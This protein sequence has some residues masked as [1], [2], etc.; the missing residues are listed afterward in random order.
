MTLDIQAVR[1]A[2]PA[3]ASGF[4][5]GD[6]A[7]GSQCLTDVVSRISDYLLNTNVQLGADYPVSVTSTNRVASGAEA[8]R[9]LFNAE[10][11]D[12]IAYGSSSTMIVEN[13]SRAIE[14]DVQPGEEIII[15]GE[16]ESNAGPWKKLAARKGAVLKLW[17]ATQ[18]AQ[19][20]DNPYAV[21]LQ[22]DALAPLISSKTR[23]V[24][25]TACSN[26][27]GSIVSVKDIISAARALAV[28]RGARK[29]EF[30]VDCVA[31]APH[32]QIDVQDW[33]VEYCYFSFYKVYGP[34]ASVLYARSTSL[35]HSLSS[36]AHH[37]LK[38]DAKPYKLQPGGP[39]YELV[40]GCTGVPPYLR[41]LTPEGTLKAAWTAIAQHEQ[42]LLEP[43]LAYLRAKR[44]RG[45]RIVGDE[46]AGLGR[47][48][49]VSF[50]V[51]GERA[52]RS[53]DV[54]KAFDAKG[55]VG[56]RY[57]HFYAYTLVDKLEPKLNVDDGVVRI[58]LVHYNTVEEVKRL[59]DILD[60]VLA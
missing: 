31:Y 28:E 53:P 9:E 2:F 10:S 50:V 29:I 27:L 34:H 26:I 21:G 4:L 13:F 46:G 60:E 8:A 35:Q 25:F 6:N 38:V 12:E 47:V 49:T 54:V 15:T 7:G 24:A 36:L 33:D 23:I 40:Y 43:L 51:V 17:P 18:L 45:V 44:E 52:I 41:S 58:S 32:R 22:L 56:I 48:P 37:F 55:N 16:H 20:P 42:S 59:I 11:V 5:Y 57:G 19:Y 3:L 39:G 14:A 30:C 1:T